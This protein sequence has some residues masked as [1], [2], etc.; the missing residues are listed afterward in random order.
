MQHFSMPHDVRTRHG[1]EDHQKTFV[2]IHERVLLIA[3][4]LSKW[5][6]QRQRAIAGVLIRHALGI[7]VK[8]T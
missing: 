8:F 2:F 4:A 6:C 7:N 5:L 1:Y 3:A